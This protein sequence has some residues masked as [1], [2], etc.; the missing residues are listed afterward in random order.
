MDMHEREHIMTVAL[1]RRRDVD[2][3]RA[4]YDEYADA[5]AL[6]CEAVADGRDVTALAATTGAQM[7]GGRAVANARTLARFA[8]DGKYL[9]DVDIDE[10]A[11]LAEAVSQ[12]QR[13]D[14]LD[15]AA[16]TDAPLCA[17]GYRGREDGCPY[18]A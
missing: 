5:A 16:E 12:E 3:E 14:L 1:L 15:L 13:L 8:A 7:A 9:G 11:L 10:E 18:R 4:T 17:H 2:P 6:V